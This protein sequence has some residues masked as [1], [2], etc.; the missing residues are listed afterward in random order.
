M[1]YNLRNTRKFQV[2]DAL[3]PKARQQILSTLLLDV[4]KPWYLSDM[5]QHNRTTPSTLQRELA[6]LVKVGILSKTR[7][8]NRTYYQADSTCP[9][10]PELRSLIIKTSGL[11]GQVRT[12]LQPLAAEIRVAF[13]YGSFATHSERS[14][15]DVDL[16]V[17]GS[18]KLARLALA[19]RPLEAQLSR[20]IN[21]SLYSEPEF[22]ERVHSGRHFVTAL[23]SG[24]K[25]FILGSQS[26]LESIA[27][28][29]ESDPAPDNQERN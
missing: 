6:A 11:V 15:S 29:G 23:L 7:D 22:V 17:V 3:F 27:Q 14:S 12:A 9:V 24:P 8:G 25:L 16:L 18:V 26:D 4:S 19:L 10:L 21:P 28:R 5:A 2:L 20:P 13:V 1:R